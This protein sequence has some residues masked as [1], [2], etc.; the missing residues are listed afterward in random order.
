LSLSTRPPN[1]SS[2]WALPLQHCQISTA[3]SISGISL[4]HF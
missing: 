3:A 1:L 2:I 4:R